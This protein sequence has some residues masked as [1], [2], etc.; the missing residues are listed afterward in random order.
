MYSSHLIFGKRQRISPGFRI[1]NDFLCS[2]L[3][4]HGFSEKS[5]DYFPI[6]IATDI[7][8]NTAIFFKSVNRVKECKRF[9]FVFLIDY[10]PSLPR[11]EMKVCLEKSLRHHG[12]SV[13]R[14]FMTNLQERFPFKSMT[15]IPADKMSH[16][17]FRN[18][19]DEWLLHENYVVLRYTE[20][21]IITGA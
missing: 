1:C 16:H 5:C 13:E 3:V 18:R 15:I 20:T 4:R 10:F 17:D 7:N 2:S 21:V 11:D 19:N 9:T 6:R 14:H 8:M 12:K